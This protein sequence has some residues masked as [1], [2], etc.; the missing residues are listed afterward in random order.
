MAAA[1]GLCPYVCGFRANVDCSDRA[2]QNVER[3]VDALHRRHGRRVALIG[4]SRG[5]HFARAM[6][7]RAPDRV[8]HAISLGAD[9]RDLV[10]ISVPTLA[11][12]AAVHRGLVLPR[13][14]RAERCFTVDCTCEFA[15]D[16]AR[17]F[18]SDQVRLTSIY[19]KRDDCRWDTYRICEFAEILGFYGLPYWYP[20]QVT[21]LGLGPIWMSGN[22]EAKRR[23]GAQ[24]EA[25]EVFAFGL[26]E[27]AHGAD[28]YSTDMVL[29]PDGDGGYRANGVKYYIG[30]GNAAR[31]VS[32]FGKFA[33]S[34]EYVF[35]AADSQHPNY[36]LIGNVINSQNYVSTYALR[37]Y[38]V[39]EAN[40]LHRGDDARNATLNTVNVGKYNLGSASVGNWHARVL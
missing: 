16:Y 17:S 15:Q 18:P 34:D 38:P 28:V 30:N 12:V 39:N 11:A 22:E 1:P 31:M 37:D 3:R 32:T 33:D 29:T 23:A 8:S 6:G 40:I 35:F 2:L 20:F 14:T 9:L 21:V 4:H 10:G 5:G 27:R 13:R 7:G 19:S 24:L 36:E 26:S 25:G